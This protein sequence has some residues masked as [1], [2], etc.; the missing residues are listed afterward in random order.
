MIASS[1]KDGKDQGCRYFFGGNIMG[2][3]GLPP[4]L[5]YPRKL[6]NG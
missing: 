3:S 6:V 1:P 5:E 4:S 2:I